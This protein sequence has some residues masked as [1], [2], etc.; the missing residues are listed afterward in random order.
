MILHVK[1]GNLSSEHVSEGSSLTSAYQCEQW[2][3]KARTHKPSKQ[4]WQLKSRTRHV[5]R[6]QGNAM[7]AQTTTP[8]SNPTILRTSSYR[9]YLKYFIIYVQLRTSEHKSKTKYHNNLVRKRKDKNS[10]EC[11]ER[12]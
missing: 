9:I 3:C 1:C 12:N 5:L 6:S 10:N 8:V 7:S 2:L 4:M 11:G